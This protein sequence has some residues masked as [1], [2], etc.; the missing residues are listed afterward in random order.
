[1]GCLGRNFQC[2][3]VNSFYSHCYIFT[4]G[5]KKFVL[6]QRGANERSGSNIG[7]IAVLPI[8]GRKQIGNILQLSPDD[9]AVLKRDA[10]AG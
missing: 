3:P 5:R 9:D 8:T 10:H 7:Q 6:Q 2:L 4:F 1:M